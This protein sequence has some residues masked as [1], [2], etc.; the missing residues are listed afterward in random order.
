MGSGLFKLSFSF[1]DSVVFYVALRQL[2]HYLTNRFVWAFRGII[3]FK[4]DFSCSFSHPCCTLAY[5]TSLTKF[6]F[7]SP[8][9]WF[10]HAVSFSENAIVLLLWEGGGGQL[11]L[12]RYVSSEFTS[13]SY[14]FFLDHTFFF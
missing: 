1:T 3:R 10:T 8:I 12:R 6:L 13:V 9:F 7:L 4:V 11:L 14:I 2:I 5:I